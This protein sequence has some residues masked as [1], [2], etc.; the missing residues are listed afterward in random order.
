MPYKFKP[1]QCKDVI[2]GGARCQGIAVPTSKLQMCA[3]HNPIAGGDDSEYAEYIGG[4]EEEKAPVKLIG[5]KK[6]FNQ[7]EV[8]RADE[9]D[10]YEELIRMQYK[11]TVQF[12]LSISELRTRGGTLYRNAQTYVLGAT[13][14]MPMRAYHFPG[15]PA[16]VTDSDVMR[17]KEALIKNGT[18]DSDFL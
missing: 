12:P 8:K 17:L 9:A 11:K 15:H 5:E 18:L 4:D 14:T 3:Q 13:K 10:P 6:K 1:K 2:G 16:T 7:F